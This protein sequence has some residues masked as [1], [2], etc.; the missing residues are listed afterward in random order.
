VIK[1]YLDDK[2]IKDKF[3]LGKK[4]L[5]ITEFG[6]FYIS[7]IKE[8]GTDKGIIVHNAENAEL[9]IDNDLLKKISTLEVSF[10]NL[11]FC[12]IINFRIKQKN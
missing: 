3:A 10:R 4:H 9:M 5:I 1:K 7:I 12:Y 11:N 2:I 6:Y 8:S